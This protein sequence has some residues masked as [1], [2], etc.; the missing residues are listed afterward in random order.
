MSAPL[1]DALRSWFERSSRDIALEA[2][3][4]DGLGGLRSTFP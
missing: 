2:L 4:R 1:P 3:Q